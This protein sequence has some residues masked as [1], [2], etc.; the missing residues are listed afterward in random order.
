MKDDINEHEAV[1]ELM[2]HTP[3]HTVKM[4]T[5]VDGVPEGHSTVAIMKR[6]EAEFW[7]LM[8]DRDFC[9]LLFS[10]SIGLGLFNA[11]LTLIYQIV[12]PFG[13][14]NDD[15]GMFAAVLIVCGLIGAGVCGAIM[16][17]THAYRTV[18]KGGF[19]TCFLGM[20][21][22]MTMLYLNN[23]AM[24]SFTFGVLGFFMLP[25]LP[26]TLENC[27]ECTFPIA[28][29]LS[30]GLLLIGGNVVGI[31]IILILQVLLKAEAWGP[32]PFLPSNVFMLSLLLVA[33][34]SLFFYNG[35]YYRLQC[36]QRGDGGAGESGKTVGDVDASL[37]DALLVR[38]ASNN[39]ASSNSTMASS[40]VDS[41]YYRP[42]GTS[43]SQG[44]TAGL[45]VDVVASS[46]RR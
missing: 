9:I 45:L 25:M 33:I 31:P 42:T 37:T 8:G 20:I 44:A 22:F 35:Q 18:L 41:A 29:E 10:F 12:E 40:R 15:S 23:Y 46:G 38:V 27:A 7:Q 30:V 13:Y 43:Q 36:E 14:S 32:P 26:A 2:S 17:H 1:P 4:R 28:E 6:S 21:F 19:F 5:S 34:A 16:D 3:N 39:T 24:L 11:F